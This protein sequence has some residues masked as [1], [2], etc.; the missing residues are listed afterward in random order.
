VLQ[1]IKHWPEQHLDQTKPDSKIGRAI[2][3]TLGNWDQR[4]GYVKDGKLEIDNNL[5]ENKIRLLALG[6]K[7]FLF[8]GNHTA[9]QNAAMMYSFMGTCKA[10]DVNP[11]KWLEAALEKL[12]YCASQDDYGELLRQNFMEV[13]LVGWVPNKGQIRPLVIAQIG[14][15][16]EIQFKVIPKNSHLAVVM[17]LK[18]IGV[19]IH[20]SII[21]ADQNPNTLSGCKSCAA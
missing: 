10:N 16:K 13:W 9:A 12:A 3:Y 18:V 7:N 2:T 8:S 21:V 20:S 1:K 11:S 17:N 14:G 15:H 6:R 5:A 4:S 19:G